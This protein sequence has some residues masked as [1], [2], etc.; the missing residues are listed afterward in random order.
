M[1]YFP[2][3]ISRIYGSEGD[4][5]GS[6]IIQTDGIKRCYI[7]H[8]FVGKHGEP[9]E[10]HHVMNGALRD[11]ADEQGLWI[12]ITPECH[13]MLHENWFGAMVQKSL[14]KQIAQIKFEELHSHEEWM[15]KVHKNYV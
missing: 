8:A 3:N 10:K 4:M 13:R 15:E 2:S 9:L 7:S 11:W 6:S 14:L 5:S 12:W 1:S